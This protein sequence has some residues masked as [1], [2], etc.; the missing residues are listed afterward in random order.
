MFKAAPRFA[1]LA[2]VFAAL[3]V[4]GAASA[5]DTVPYKGNYLSGMV[6][7]NSADKSQV[8]GTGIST[9][10]KFGNGW[11]GALAFG[12]AYGNGLRV[13][14][15]LAR[16][17]NKVD[18]ISAADGVGD[19]VSDSVMFNTLYDFN[20]GGRVVPY[21]GAGLGLARVDWEVSPIGGSSSDDSDTNFAWQ[22]MIGVALPLSDSLALTAE[23]RHFDAGSQDIRLASGT[24]VNTDYKSNSLMIGLRWNFGA[25]KPRM[26]SAAAPAPAP[27]K[28]SAPMPV[29]KPAPAPVPVAQPRAFLIFFDWDRTNIRPDA[30]QILE[31]AARAVKQG[32]QVRIALTG[33][34][35]RSGRTS[36]NQRLSE[37]RAAAAKAA[38]VTL[39]I[40]A[41]SIA[42]V[43]RG[44]SQPLVA[45]A[46]GVRE[47]RNR[48]VEIQF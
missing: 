19:V 28:E 32:K 40:P 23:A 13:E 8:Y 30:Q 37:R 6:G 10:A 35:D 4:A 16:R 31:A 24:S 29:P 42:T 20:V 9:T 7:L 27:M 5:Q 41:S 2:L 47:P 26:Q 38:M 45:T 21:I 33:H 22:A 11:A 1:A 34:A 12:H 17:S 46:D 36:Y 48:R 15:E 3:T 18:D 43:G 25:P 14:G 44:E 39:G